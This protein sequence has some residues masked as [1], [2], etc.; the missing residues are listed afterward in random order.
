[1]GFRVRAGVGV[2]GVRVRI[3]DRDRVRVRVRVCQRYTVQHTVRST[4]S[5]H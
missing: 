2:F 4:Q 1:M 5:R 3:G